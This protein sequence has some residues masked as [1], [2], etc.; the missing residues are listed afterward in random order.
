MP[1]DKNDVDIY[2]NCIAINEESD[3]F[4]EKTTQE[5]VKEPEKTQIIAESADCNKEDDTNEPVV[6]LKISLS[7]GR[8]RF[9][10]QTNKKIISHIK[11]I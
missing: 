7:N 4:V 10:L 5:S 8:K 11:K 1:D 2:Q 3:N 9:K 6:L